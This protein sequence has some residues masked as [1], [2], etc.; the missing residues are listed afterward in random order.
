[1]QLF[2]DGTYQMSS[3]NLPQA[4]EKSHKMFFNTLSL[5]AISGDLFTAYANI[6]F[7]YESESV[8]GVLECRSFAGDLFE[9][10]MKEV[11]GYVIAHEDCKA[12]IISFL[13]LNPETG[14]LAAVSVCFHG[15]LGQNLVKVT[16][17]SFEDGELLIGE[18]EGP[19]V[20]NMGQTLT[21]QLL[22]FWLNKHK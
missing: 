21:L 13:N 8:C 5:V 4:V 10:E 19:F 3:N 9:K 11:T 2:T 17:V 15:E 1:M 12:V 16:D 7:C 22:D 6:T 20:A 14:A 18:S